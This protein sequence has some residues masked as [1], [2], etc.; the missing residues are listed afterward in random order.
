MASLLKE[1]EATFLHR[2]PD[3]SSLMLTEMEGADGVSFLCPKCWEANGRTNVG[4]HTIIC[5]FE[6]VPAEVSPGPGRWV[7]QG[8]GLHDLTFIS[9]KKHPLRSV[10]LLSGCKWHGF[11]KQGDAA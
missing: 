5:W 7:P 3:G 2:R 11:V 6:H 4:V 1:L 9:T 10:L 8:T